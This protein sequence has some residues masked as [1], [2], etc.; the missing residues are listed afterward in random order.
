MP[1]S[2]NDDPAK[3]NNT[4]QDI[5]N[6]KF[7]VKYSDSILN[8]KY[9]NNDLDLYVSPNILNGIKRFIET[10]EVEKVIFDMTN[11]LYI[12]SSAIGMFISLKSILEKSKSKFTLVNLTKNVHKIL[13]HVDLIA[14]LTENSEEFPQL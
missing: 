12:D 8:L 2:E 6:D 14:F 13:S 7:D 1:F 5:F 3:N 10:S 11:V 9:L 4:E